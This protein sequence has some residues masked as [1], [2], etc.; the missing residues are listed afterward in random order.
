MDLKLNNLQKVICHKTQPTY[1]PLI[2]IPL[3]FKGNFQWCC[4][5]CAGLQYYVLFLSNSHGEG[6]NPFIYPA[7]G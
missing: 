7:I 5:Q 3:K 1:Q 6:V 4:G 2:E